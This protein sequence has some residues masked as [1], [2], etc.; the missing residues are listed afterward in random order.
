MIPGGRSFRGSRGACFAQIL[1]KN[2]PATPGPTESYEPQ[3]TP[4]VSN[5]PSTE[6][7]AQQVKSTFKPGEFKNFISL[8]FQPPLSPELVHLTNPDN[9]LH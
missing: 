6:A 9:R 3:C 5:G 4:S 7:L 8:N 2:L 1:M